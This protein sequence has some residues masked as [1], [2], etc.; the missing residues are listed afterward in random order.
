MSTFI[1][2]LERDLAEAIRYEIRSPSNRVTIFDSIPE[3]YY[4]DD[5]LFK[6]KVFEDNWA[7]PSSI[8][9]YS[10][11]TNG[12]SLMKALGFCTQR[13]FPNVKFTI[14]HNDK[15]LS[16]L[17]ASE[18]SET[19]WVPRGYIPSGVDVDIDGGKSGVVF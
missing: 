13:T 5:G 12:L 15:D 19:G 1:I 11:F 17:K 2:G 6:V 3:Q 14:E 10:Y 4:S 7:I 16:I 9:F 18:V 8:I